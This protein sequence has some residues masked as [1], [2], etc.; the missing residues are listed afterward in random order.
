MLS[1]N[2]HVSKS[3]TLRTGETRVPS[4]VL[5]KIFRV[6]FLDE[7]TTSNITNNVEHHQSPRE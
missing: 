2:Q 7:E 4:V 5:T 1:S 6:T 3:L